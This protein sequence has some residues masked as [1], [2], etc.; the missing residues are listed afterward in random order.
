MNSNRAVLDALDQEGVQMTEGELLRTAK[1]RTNG[2]DSA[3]AMAAPPTNGRVGQP[4]FD[5]ERTAP[6]ELPEGRRSAN[7]GSSLPVAPSD[8]S[9]WSQLAGAAINGM[10]RVW[11]G[12]VEVL[13]EA[14]WLLDRDAKC[15]SVGLQT[16]GRVE[17]KRTEKHADPES[18]S[19]SYTHYVTYAYQVDG[20]SH[21][22]EKRVNR[23]GG[24]KKDDAIRVYF[25]PETVKPDSA[26]DLEPR[27][28]TE[29]AQEPAKIAD[30]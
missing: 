30:E 22:Q 2:S 29:R 6:P 3:A 7:G 20:R 25:L 14:Y 16:V 12:F 28:L 11:V 9:R 1:R 13:R 27:A 8:G 18:G 10:Q 17:S 23:F 4:A 19:T 21:L 26:I 24:L 15:R 5:L